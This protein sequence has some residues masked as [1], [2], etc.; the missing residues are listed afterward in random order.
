M[1]F[2]PFKYDEP[3]FRPPAEANSVII[4]AT[5]GCSWNR[6]AFCEMYTSKKF[7]VKKFSDLQSD[8]EILSKYYKGAKKIFLA[9]GNAFVLSASH[10]I[11]ILQ[12]ITKCFGKIQRISSYALPK[13]ICNKTAAELKEIRDQGLRLLYIGV[14]SGDDELLKMIH[15]GETFNSTV[16]GILKAHEAGID[17]SLMV[18]NG[19]GGRQ[20]SEQH[21]INSTALINKTN[22]KF[23]STLTLS[24]PLGTEHF[25]EKFMG[26]YVPQ[27]IL[28][29]ASELKLFI[30]HTDTTNTI[31]RSDHVSN[32]LVL[33]GVLSKDKEAMIEAI[34]KAGL[35]ID[36]NAYP[37]TPRYL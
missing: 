15:K 24:F 31:F 5:I 18:L 8:I 28:E 34:E 25:K 1:F 16:D 3:V 14:E 20:Y 37:V 33:K 36:K 23:L 22:P 11:P 30:K 13:D 29:L 35:L 7:R 26:E 10:L 17:T 6:C 32:N 19:L 12:E 2:T 4:Q 21:A 27:T 9:D